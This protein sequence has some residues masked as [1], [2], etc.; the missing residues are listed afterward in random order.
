MAGIEISVNSIEEMC[1]LMCDNLIPQERR[2]RM[3]RTERPV[4]G[5]CQWHKNYTGEWICMNTDSEY[6][7]LETEYED[8]C[9]EHE[10]R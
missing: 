4:C 1:V 6:Y 3:S 10:E 5:D 9:E 8:C 2:K 7:G